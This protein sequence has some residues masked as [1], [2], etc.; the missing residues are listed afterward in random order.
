MFKLFSRP[1]IIAVL[2]AG[3]CFTALPDAKAMDPVTISL[4]APLAIKAGSIAMP[5]AMRGLRCG[6]VQM[7]RMGR[8]TAEILYLPVGVIQATLGIPFGSFKNGC[9]NIYT[10]ITAPLRL[11]WDTLMLPISLTGVTPM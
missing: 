2:I 7:V 3:C 9:A 4:F 5:Y 6:A 1:V 10:G 8:D 11:V